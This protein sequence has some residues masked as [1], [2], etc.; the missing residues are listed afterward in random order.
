[1]KLL[2]KDILQE[3]FNYEA[4]NFLKKKKK[5]NLLE[6]INEEFDYKSSIYIFNKIK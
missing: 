6:E 5:K 3:F 1:M 2:N 4:L